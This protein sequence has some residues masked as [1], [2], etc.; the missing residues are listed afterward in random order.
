MIL[1]FSMGQCLLPNLRLNV[2]YFDASLIQNKLNCIQAT[3]ILNRTITTGI[4]HGVIKA[5]YKWIPPRL[6][7]HPCVGK[8]FI[9]KSNTSSWKIRQE[10]YFPEMVRLSLR[11]DIKTKG[12]CS[13][14]PGKSCLQSSHLF[15]LHVKGFTCP[16]LIV[17]PPEQRQIPYSSL[18]RAKETS[19]S[20]QLERPKLGSISRMSQELL[21][22][23]ALDHLCSSNC[24]G[25]W[26]T[27]SQDV[28]STELLGF[29]GKEHTCQHLAPTFYA[30]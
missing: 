21:L 29:A 24:S 3:L 19:D 1:G 13:K 27:K 15:Y 23:S 14:P 5:C 28:L 22:E 4:Y 9:Q 10:T 11:T 7:E 6:P 17:N 30:E 25:K 12:I 20:N 8:L 16:Y 18:Q 26:G 2:V